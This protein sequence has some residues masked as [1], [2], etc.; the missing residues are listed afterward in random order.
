MRILKTATGLLITVCM[1]FMM[2]GCGSTSTSSDIVEIKWY[3]FSPICPDDKVVFDAVNEYTEEK[4]GVRVNYVPIPTSEYKEKMNMLL[5]SNDKFDLCFTAAYVDYY[6]HARNG[7]FLELDELLENEGKDVLAITPDYSLKA[8]TVNGKLYALPLIKDVAEKYVYTFNKALCEKYGIDDYLNVKS[9][10][11]L[12]PIFQVI[13]DNEP[14]IYPTLIR[15][16]NNLFHFL[17]FEAVSGAE[18]VAIEMTNFDKVVNPYATEEAKEF[19]ALMRE[20]YQKGFV[21]SDAAT[22]L[23]DNDIRN[24]NN[25]FSCWA[26][27]LPS[28]DFQTD[29]PLD[30]QSVIAHGLDTA[31]LR[32]G[33]V[34]GAA[35]AISANSKN[36]E[37]TMEFINLLNTDTYLRNLVGLGIEGKHY[38]KV[39][40]NQYDLPEGVKTVQDTGYFPTQYTQA[41]R[42]LL[43]VHKDSPANMWDKFREFNDSAVPY[44]SFGFVYEPKNVQN[45]IVAVNNVYAEFGPSL[46]VGAVDPEVYLPQFISKLE[47]VGIQRIIDDVQSQYDEWK[48]RGN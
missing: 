10:E 4:I 25:F 12:T 47:A 34:M 8:A 16:N 41:N 40:D 28:N 19:F 7:S 42:F 46:M 31:H 6:V 24:T 26:G 18:R 29:R 15:G 23:N 33:N 38:I 22:A 5:A 36:P 17:P 20:W 44:G 30:K 39:N 3:A 21:R 27:Y 11:D 13:K 1:V 37:K 45:E 2:V 35:Y 43:Y 32:T 48:A 9:L 14:G